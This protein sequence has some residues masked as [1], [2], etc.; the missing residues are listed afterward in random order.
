MDNIWSSSVPRHRR[1]E[2]L[3]T[4]MLIIYMFFFGIIIT[5]AFL[6]SL[7]RSLSEFCVV[8]WGRWIHTSCIR[9]P[10][11]IRPH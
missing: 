2:L 7:V 1:Y 3:A 8:N 9:S 11:S 4:G 10:S 6:L 5:I